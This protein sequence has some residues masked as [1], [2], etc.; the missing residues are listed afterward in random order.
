[1]KIKGLHP[2]GGGL[3]C[4]A[5]LVRALNAGQPVVGVQSRL[6]SGE[7]H[8][9]STIQD[10]VQDYTSIIEDVKPQGSLTL[11]GYSFG[12]LLAL[13]TARCLVSLGRRVAY[14]FLIEPF[15]GLVWTRLRHTIGS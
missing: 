3:R 7:R 11:L 15:W 1:M 13:E 10:M 5:P 4:Y 12:G 2:I 9:H 8:E 14:L 6:L